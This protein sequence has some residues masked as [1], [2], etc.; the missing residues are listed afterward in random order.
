MPLRPFTS[1]CKFFRRVTNEYLSGRATLSAS[2]EKG[3][4]KIALVAY[5][6]QARN[7]WKTNIQASQRQSPWTMASRQKKKRQHGRTAA[8]L[9]IAVHRLE[10]ASLCLAVFALLLLGFLSFGSA[11]L[12]MQRGVSPSRPYL[13]FVSLL[14]P[15]SAVRRAAQPGCIE[16]K[17]PTPPCPIFR[18]ACVPF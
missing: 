16:G 14:L 7:I 2:S 5:A 3:R 11:L 6:R 10:E 12:T 4:V 9:Q 1:Y 13:S 18:F 15:G 8:R 17:M